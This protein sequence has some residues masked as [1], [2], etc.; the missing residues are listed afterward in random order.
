MITASFTQNSLTTI[1]LQTRD[2]RVKHFL[3][4]R[5]TFFMGTRVVRVEIFVDIKDDFAGISIGIGNL[6]K[7]GSGFSWKRSDLFI[8]K[9]DF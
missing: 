1:G 9:F 3:V 8:Q 4:I 7:K 5:S 6:Q 2:E